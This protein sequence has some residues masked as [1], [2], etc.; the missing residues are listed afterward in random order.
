MIKIL[1]FF[2]SLELGGAQAVRLS[3][4]LA[5]IKLDP[6]LKH[7]IISF[8][9]GPF[10][11]D[12]QRAGVEVV[13]LNSRFLPRFFQLPRLIRVM[14]DYDP[15]VIHSLPWVPN[16]FSRTVLRL[17]APQA[18]IICD[19]HGTAYLSWVHRFLDRWTWRLADFWIFVTIDLKKHFAL[20]WEA[21]IGNPRF[22]VVHNF[23]DE[24]RF[25]VDSGLRLATRVG[26]GVESS[27]VLGVA[28]RLDRVKRLDWLVRCFSN[29]VASPL[30]SQ[31]KLLIA[32]SGSEEKKLRQLVQ[33]LK[34][35]EK[36]LFLQLAPED[37]PS[38]YN[39]LDLFVLCS[40][41]EGQPLVLMEAAAC[42]APVLLSQNLLDQAQVFT[43]D[44]MFFSNSC[45]FFQQVEIAIRKKIQKKSFLA[46]KF[47]KAN[48]LSKLQNLYK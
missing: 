2:H 22:V 38:F 4:I 1:H 28:A 15:D 12:A 36:V 11:L 37:M 8:K 40:E 43:H 42:G 5:L 34:I 9:T 31:I 41:S 16:F 25:R 47:N 17:F 45:E 18:K 26:W 13:V 30:G 44:P 3:A 35:S 20:A 39:S 48:F 6:V 14:W 46:L 33:D 29:L 27:F 10:L 19:F 24:K 32:G 7:K 23:V 21:E